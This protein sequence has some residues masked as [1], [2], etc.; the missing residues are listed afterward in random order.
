MTHLLSLIPY[1]SLCLLYQVQSHNYT[2]DISLQ[3]NSFFDGFIF[4]TIDDP[5]HGYVDYVDAEYAYGNGLAY[6]TTDEKVFIGADSINVVGDYDRGRKSIRLKSK[7]AYN[8]NNLIVIDLDHMP[9]TNGY[10]PAGCSAWPAFWLFGPDWPYNGEI[11][12]IEYQNSD[13]IVSTTLHTNDGCDQSG[14]DT[15]TFTGHWGTGSQG[16][17]SDNCDVNAWDQWTNEGCGIIGDSQPVGQSFNDQGGGVYAT[18]WV[19]DEYIRVFYFP[20]GYVPE[21]LASR[22]NPNPDTWGTP[23]A[24]FELGDNCPSS[25]FIDNQIVFDITF[26]GDWAGATFPDMCSYDVSCTDY[27]KYN[28]DTFKESYW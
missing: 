17:P 24:R 3:G 25:H 13:S 9:T 2:M 11:D 18:E 12:V 6:V 5:T 26:C 7:Q 16:N 21:D 20:H 19:V 22:T 28:P 15:S 8:G 14:E 10:L 27:V 4:E 23:Y 1:L